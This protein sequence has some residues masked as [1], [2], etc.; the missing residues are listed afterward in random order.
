MMVTI[1]INHSAVRR[2]RLHRYIPTYLVA[3][4]MYFLKGGGSMGHKYAKRAFES[5][6][7]VDVPDVSRFSDLLFPLTRTLLLKFS[8]C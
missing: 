1:G 8:T 7:A 4:E 5:Y 6:R 2:S 3:F